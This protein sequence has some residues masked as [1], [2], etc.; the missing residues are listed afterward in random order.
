MSNIIVS[1]L[2]AN[3]IQRLSFDE[4]NAAMKTIGVGGTLVPDSFD[5]T[6]I[7]YIVSGQGIGQIGLVEYYSN[8]I[9]IASLQLTYDIS[10]RLIRVQRI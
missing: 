10:D 7:T 9:L 3:Q 5:D 8:N 6:Q 2:D 4:A 1:K